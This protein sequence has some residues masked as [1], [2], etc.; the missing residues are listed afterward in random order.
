M[1]PPGICCPLLLGYACPVIALEWT[2][3]TLPAADAPSVVE[4]FS[5]YCPPCFE[6]PQMLGVDQAIH[7]VLQEGD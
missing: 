2:R 1:P 5:F 7:R 6:F 3:I 4:F